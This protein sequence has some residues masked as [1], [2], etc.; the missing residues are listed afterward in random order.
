MPLPKFHQSQ[1]HARLDGPERRRRPLRRSP[2]ASGPRNRPARAPGAG[3]RAAG[4]RRRG[5]C[6]SHWRPAEAAST[7]SGRGRTLRRAPRGSAISGREAG[8]AR[9]EP[10]DRAAA[11]RD[12]QPGEDVAAGR[13]RTT[14]RSATRRGRLPGATS[15]ASPPSPR[16]R[17]ARPSS[18]PAVPVVEL[19]RARPRPGPR[20]GPSGRGRDRR[21][22]GSSTLAELT[23]ARGARLI[24]SR[25]RSVNPEI[26]RLRTRVP[27]RRFFHAAGR[28]RSDSDPALEAT[29]EDGHAGIPFRP[30]GA[31]CSPRSS[32]LDARGARARLEPPRG[33]RASPTTRP[34]TTP[35]STSSA[36]RSIPSRL[37]MIS[38]WI[39][40]EEPAGGPNY[41]HFEP[42]I[43]YEFNVDSERRRARGHRLPRRVHAQR[44]QRRHVPPEHRPRR[45]RRATRTRTSTTPT[46]SRSA[47]GRRR[48]RRTAR[49]SAPTCS[50]RRTT[51][52]PSRFRT[53]TA[54]GPT[55]RRRSTTSTTTPRSS[56]AR[57]PRAS[58]STSA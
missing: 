20:P 30:R 24:P 7:S 53:A 13:D 28:R 31:G 16:M 1:P 26:A 34:P 21:V 3:P 4:R 36:T 38:N 33:A 55:S 49:C 18:R 14:R 2:A 56:P 27:K 54:R 57:A 10:V 35:T 40:L 5:R 19:G 37:V 50:R 32:P 8:T 23:R 52:D 41:F 9:A 12:E 46:P 25:A 6:A 45:P 44:P 48:A 29:E 39:P 11:G 51:S 47:S 17:R 15:S 43:R 42:N 58:T 22:S